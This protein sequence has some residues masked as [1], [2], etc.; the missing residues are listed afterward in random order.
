MK[1]IATVLVFACALVGN[2]TAETRWDLPTNYAASAFHTKNI[3][4]FSSD[5]EKA[6]G[7]SLKLVV[8]P[9]G[10]MGR[11]EPVVENDAAHHSPCRI[12]KA[13]VVN[14]GRKIVKPRRYCP[15]RTIFA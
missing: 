6:T 15:G 2:A 5:V 14:K 9:G 8:H 11:T 1:G 7:G 4:Q 3:V 13:R 10:A 12:E